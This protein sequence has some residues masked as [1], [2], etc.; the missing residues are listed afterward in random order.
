MA[1]VCLSVVGSC[2][3]NCILRGGHSLRAGVGRRTLHCRS[4]LIL[5]VHRRSSGWGTDCRIHG[6]RG[7]RGRR[8]RGRADSIRHRIPTWR[9]HLVD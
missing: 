7:R 4:N 1:P 2:S 6:R 5:G 8:G 9:Q 3:F